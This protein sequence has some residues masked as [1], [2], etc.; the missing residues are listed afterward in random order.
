M[1]IA[2]PRYFDYGSNDYVL[3]LFGTA[4]SV[5]TTGATGLKVMAGPYTTTTASIG[6][7]CQTI[8]SSYSMA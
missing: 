2:T 3:Q 1:K 8:L 6:C 4:N 5:P 7:G